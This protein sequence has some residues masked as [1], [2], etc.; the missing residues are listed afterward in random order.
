[1]TDKEEEM[2]EFDLLQEDIKEKSKHTIKAYKSAYRKLQSLLKKDIYP[3]DQK[4]I[5]NLIENEKNKNSQQALLNIAI[6][7]KRLYKRKTN[8]LEEQREVNKK[9]II[10]TVKKTNDKIV[11]PS[12]NDIEEYIDYLYENS[13]WA[14]YIINYLLINFQVRNEDINFEIISK[15]GLATDKN[16]NYM[17]LSPKGKIVYIRN[18][19]KTNQTYGKKE[20]EIKDKEFLVALRRIK[21]RGD[22]LIPNDNQVGYYVMKATYKNIGE[23]N[24]FKILVNAYKSNLQKLKEM[25]EN[26][27]SSLNVIAT[28]YDI[29]LKTEEEEK[30]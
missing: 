8:L 15:K 11:L 29:D 1:M 30:E 26:R 10:D 7:V 5:I 19:Y 22:I 24:Y 16:K 2:T 17:W 9:N 21:A 3:A 20:H 14:D 6:L 4:T 12:L 27:G 28:N 13:Q 23:G 25:A 18:R